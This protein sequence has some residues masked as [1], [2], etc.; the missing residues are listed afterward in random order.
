[1]ALAASR[2]V[3]LL[4]DLLGQD[5]AELN[6]PLVEAVDVPDGTLGEGEVLIVD[7]K[8]TEFGGANRATN[9]DGSGR[10]VAKEAL[11]GDKVASGSLSLDLLVSLANHQ[12]LSLGEEVGC[13]HLLVK[14]VGN[15]V[16]GLSGQDEVGGNQLGTLVN[17]LEEGVLGVGARLAKEDG[18]WARVSMTEVQYYIYKDLPVVYLTEEPSEAIDLPLD[19]MDNCWR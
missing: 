17:K 6:T 4:Q 1:M 3:K 9:E 7:D 19:S 11:V 5:L 2:L 13:Q 12:S 16:V 10:A 18:A 15:R 8:S 14:V